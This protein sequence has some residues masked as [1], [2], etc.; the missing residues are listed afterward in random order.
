MSSLVQPRIQIAPVGFEIDR[1]VVPAKKEKADIVY[2]IM[3]SNLSVDK[4]TKYAEKKIGRAH[5]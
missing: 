2:L 5:V 3:H 4:S 1:I